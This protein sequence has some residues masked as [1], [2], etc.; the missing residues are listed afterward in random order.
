MLTYSRARG[1]FAGISLNGA[2]IHQDKD[3][4]RALYGHMATFKSILTGVTPAA[5]GSAPFVSA[6]EK[7]TAAARAAE[8]VQK[9][10]EQKQPEQKPPEQPK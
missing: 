9:A 3:D 5:P 10:P 7:H 1:I 6:V 2:A 4:T 8:S